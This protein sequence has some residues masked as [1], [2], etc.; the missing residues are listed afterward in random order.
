MG[1]LFLVLLGFVVTADVTNYRANR[2]EL[3]LIEEQL[4]ERRRAEDALRDA[5]EQFGEQGGGAYR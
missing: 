2:R 5:N 4:A 1:G 3:L